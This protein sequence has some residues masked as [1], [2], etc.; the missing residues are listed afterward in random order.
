MKSILLTIL[1]LVTLFSCNQ[2]LTSSSMK[3]KE[4]QCDI[5][6]IN[7]G[8]FD[9]QENKGIVDIAI[10]NDSIIGISKNLKSYKGS[11]TIDGSGKFMIPGLV[12]SHVH[13]WDK[14]DLKASLNAG[15]FAVI[16]LHSSEGPD[17]YFKSLRDSIDYA[18]YYSAGYAA[19]VPG[20]HPTQL[21]PIETI[22]DKVSPTQFVENRIK[23]GA[24]LIKI[25]SGNLEPG[26]LWFGSPTLSF[27]QIEAISKEAKGRGKK[28]IVHLSQ[29]EEA[30]KIAEFGVDGF[31]HLWSYN[32]S[33]TDEQL[34]FLAMKKI[35]IVP[36]AI[37]QKKAWEQIEKAPNER[38]EF[39]GSLSTM[40][41]TYREIKRI[42]EVG[43]LILAGTD[44]PNYSIN[45][46]SDLLEELNIY[47]KAGLSNLE[48]L[49]TATGNPSSIF[50][51]DGIGMIKKGVKANFILLNSD[52]LKNISALNDINTI[53][54][55]GTKVR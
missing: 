13:L 42:H 37:L 48:V 46:T 31:A 12:N 49:K 18:S 47:S 32:Q 44:P 16:D 10:R 51:L 6:I 4:I 22:N 29:I 7:V 23:K 38:N 34:K 2:N 45:Y 19:T 15:V 25:V 8:L 1:V 39:K 9:G 54:K 3:G 26:S 35:F 5:L 33:A 43:I 14:K 52:P 27:S 55:N 24:D 40:S 53:W 50:Y 20:G 41:V 21:F 30:V 11:E 36:T 28:V 17:S